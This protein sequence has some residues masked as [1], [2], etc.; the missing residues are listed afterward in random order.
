MAVI[1]MMQRVIFF[2]HWPSDVVVGASLGFLIAGG[3]VQQGWGIG[4]LCAKLESRGENRLKVVSFE[5]EQLS[6]R[7]AA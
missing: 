4:W 3:L 7:K 5:E 1:A 6:V 2:A